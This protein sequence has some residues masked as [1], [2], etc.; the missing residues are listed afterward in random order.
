MDLTP[1]TILDWLSTLDNEETKR[2]KLKNRLPETSDWV[3]N[4]PE[5]NSW[6][7]GQSSSPV[8]WCYGLPGTGKSTI[9]SIIIAH[10]ERQISH[11]KEAL[12]YVFSNYDKKISGLDSLSSICKQLAS[13]CPELPWQLVKLYTQMAPEGKRPDIDEIM[14]L[15][16]A[17]CDYFSQVFII[18]DG[19]GGVTLDWGRETLLSKLQ[20]MRNHGARILISSGTHGDRPERCG[21]LEDIEL[22]LEDEPQLLIRPSAKDLS[23]FVEHKFKE[24]D[25]WQA[26]LQREGIH[27]DE[28]VDR[29][30]AESGGVYL[31]ADL[32]IKRAL[33]GLEFRTDSQLS[34]TL[35]A[36]SLKH[37]A[38]R[39][40]IIDKL[41]STKSTLA[42]RIFD[43][44][45]HAVV[46][47]NLSELCHAILSIKLS[48]SD[49]YRF[50]V[51]QDDVL[52]T[53]RNMGDEDSPGERISIITLCEELIHVM[54]DHHV[55]LWDNHTLNKVQQEQ[56]FPGGQFRIA[57][58][59]LLIMSKDFL[60]EWYH[61]PFR[62][63]TVDVAPALEYCQK[64]WAVHYLA[65][66]ED[67]NLEALDRWALT[68]LECIYRT[69]AR[70][71]E[72]RKPMYDKE[73]QVLITD[74]ETPIMKAARL[75]LNRLL[76][77]LIESKRYD[78]NAK[79]WKHETAMSIAVTSQHNGAVQIL[80]RYG[81]SIHYKDEY[82]QSLL[83]LAVQKDDEVMTALLLNCGLSADTPA[84]GGQDFKTPLQVAAANNSVRSGKLLLAENIDT[85]GALEAA[86]GVGALEIVKL[87]V[88]HGCKLAIPGGKDSRSSALG[89]AIRSGSVS[90][91][92]Y[93][94]AHG[95]DVSEP[96]DRRTTPIH[97]AARFGSL[98]I[99][100]TLVN[101]GADP[102][103]L[104]DGPNDVCLGDCA[105]STLVRQGNQ[106]TVQFLLSRLHP[107]VSHDSLFRIAIAAVEAKDPNLE[108]LNLILPR[109][110]RTINYSRPSIKDTL[111]GAAV[112]CNDES[113]LLNLL[114][115]DLPTQTPDDQGWTA[116]HLAA[117]SEREYAAKI[118]LNHGADP[119]E[120]S[121][122]GMT[123]LHIAAYKGNVN[124]INLLIEHGADVCMKAS[125]NS[126]P[127][128][129]AA[130]NSM[131][132]AVSLLLE[133][134]SPVNESNMN[135]ETVV[136]HAVMDDDIELLEVI[137]KY[138]P[139]LMIQSWR[140][141]SPLH[142]TAFK[143]SL[144][145]MNLL[146][147]NG[148]RL[149]Q[150]FEYH[151]GRYE[152]PEEYGWDAALCWSQRGNESRSRPHRNWSII[153][154][155]WRPLHSAVGGGHVDAVHLLLKHG[156]DLSSKDNSGETALHTAA[157][158]CF[159]GIIQVLLDHGAN[160]SE[161]NAAGDTPMHSVASAPIA[162]KNTKMANR[163]KCACTLRHEEEEKHG[164]VDHSKL[165]CVTKLLAF[166]ADINAENNLAFTP[167]ILAVQAGNEDVV[168]AI[169]SHV[170]ESSENLSKDGYLML[171][172]HCGSGA[173]A[174]LLQQ[175]SD[176]ATETI[177]SKAAWNDLLFKACPVGNHELVDLALQKGAIWTRKNWDD[178]NPFLEAVVD[179]H[180]PTVKLLLEAG[181]NPDE[182]DELGRNSLHLACYTKPDKEYKTL[183]V[184]FMDNN[185]YMIV[186]ELLLHNAQYNSRT[187][188]G[189]TPLH[190]AVVA[191]RLDI[192]RGLIALGSSVDMRNKRGETPLHVAVSTW[193][194]P[195]IVEHLLRNK[196]CASAQDLSGYTP[197]H[198]IRNRR[199]EGIRAMELLLSHGCDTSIRARNGD[200]AHHSTFK[201]GNWSVSK[202]LME[203]AGTVNEKGF[204]GRTVL[205]VAV[206][207]GQRDME[208]SLV[209]LG[210]DWEISDDSG[211]SPRDYVQER[212]NI[213][214]L[215]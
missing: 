188:S 73:Y 189:D 22:A 184:D 72:I 34:S 156:A 169:L 153:E 133:H 17:M 81:A 181:A 206:R 95:V 35:T 180:H 52:I 119:N 131:K 207:R 75:G 137:L 212:G 170:S 203:S 173:N 41:P 165:D 18:V 158:A 77:P 66:T 111:L 178:A 26:L 157:S 108:V 61:D 130:Y 1:S 33:R 62:E 172:R 44:V 183:F 187:P 56:F 134:K 112:Y 7:S 198:R 104:D 60:I 109:I 214:L 68:Y 76:E 152:P 79:S 106:E 25:N 80:Y 65:C 204:K 64:H 103:A 100:K 191:G 13:Q 129:A 12:A 142:H 27:L 114:S 36:E 208:D 196:A 174:K 53:F 175:V 49:D 105:M 211:R 199:Q 116:L 209:K 162:T 58:S 69:P 215:D 38:D 176:V 63:T 42:N 167:L 197:L 186:R 88:E 24:H 101:H 121:K 94:I 179:G 20:W 3:L 163:F 182:E 54:E 74:D 147:A 201:R 185:K 146:I 161:K 138:Q 93:M 82:G 124:L 43:W 166:G 21:C 192:V 127:L 213:I 78:I 19:I 140:A 51:S 96:D 15:N 144:K 30:T 8:L 29:V 90:L 128:V 28:F 164:H 50:L 113:V 9:S 10:L 14:L 171:L 195:D 205:H 47:L 190:F 57:L 194:F 155:G 115:Q 6:M 117:H 70:W 23:A 11:P 71:I 123:P 37:L 102:F 39:L 85:K 122:H 98:E 107:G 150:S 92:E 210:A 99:I 135:G 32:Q 16:V 132:A 31:I 67:D 200:M 145:M 97:I 110:P 83:H 193:I 159:P 118:L 143:G 168:N 59:C 148:A 48:D 120:K 89:E 5:L 2:S 125:D 40:A 141:G 136:H 139:D 84:S 87:L 177:E 4:T 149:D 202:L 160:V 91:V 154:P 46:P 45:A 86:A 151:G 126:T 55:R